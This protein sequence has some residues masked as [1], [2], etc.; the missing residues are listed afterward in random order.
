MSAIL[1]KVKSLMGKSPNTP[2]FGRLAEEMRLNGHAQKAIQFCQEGLKHRPGYATGHYVLARCYMD[3][4]QISEARESLVEALR[5]GPHHVAVITELAA[6][7]HNEG[8]ENQALYYYRQAQAIDPLNRRVRNLVDTIAEKTG[9]PIDATDLEVAYEKTTLPPPVKIES[10]ER[11]PS[12][13]DIPPPVQI[14]SDERLPAQEDITELSEEIESEESVTE[15]LE[16][17]ADLELV[18]PSSPVDPVPTIEPEPVAT[19]TPP[20]ESSPVFATGPWIAEIFQD[21]LPASEQSSDAASHGL[22]SEDFTVNIFENMLA[23]TSPGQLVEEI[24]EIA[25]EE[26]ADALYDEPE[27]QVEEISP[28][29]ETEVSDESEEDK[30]IVPPGYREENHTWDSKSI[31]EP[32]ETIEE[33]PIFPEVEEEPDTLTLD[34]S[35]EIDAEELIVSEDLPNAPMPIVPVN[36]LDQFF[37]GQLVNIQADQE[38]KSPGNPLVNE[39]ASEPTNDSGSQEID[40]NPL[41]GDT[42]ISEAIG[43]DISPDTTVSED[44]HHEESAVQEEELAPP[45]AE[46]D[47]Y[48]D[49]ED[50]PQADAI[51]TATLAEL[52]VRQGLTD[53]AISIYLVMIENDPTNPDIHKRLSELFVLK[54]EQDGP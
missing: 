26:T 11:L 41:I 51:P 34:E 48:G 38:I 7:Y 23:L 47:S 27:E 49:V 31:K 43:T 12:Q 4:N 40:N 39:N 19:S 6:L 37:I 8:N 9:E 3:E 15:E 2:Q 21:L 20:Q 33:I 32:D 25:Q 36:Y 14:E 17:I 44:S 10:D 13:E 1:D 42:S 35:H 54:A 52:Y 24:S 22:A 45:P 28:S 16:P 50:D 29:E 30:L 18:P 53:R 5:F 46:T